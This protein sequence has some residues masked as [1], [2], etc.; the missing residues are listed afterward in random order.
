MYSHM[1][2]S[3]E[4]FYTLSQKFGDDI[5]LVQGAGG[6]SSIKSL[7]KKSFLVKGSGTWLA[8]ANKKEIFLNLRREKLSHD[9]E[10]DSLQPLHEYS[11][12]DQL[13]PSIETLLHLVLPYKYVFHLHCL[14]SIA[15]CSIRNAETTLNAL[16]SRSFHLIDYFPP[17]QPLAEALLE[18]IEAKGP[19]QIFFLKNHGLV[20]VS[21]NLSEIQE[22]ADEIKLLLPP[23]NI[24]IPQTNEVEKVEGFFLPDDYSIQALAFNKNA[25]KIYKNGILYPDHVVFLGDVIPIFKTMPDHGLDSLEYFIHC[26]HGVYLK[27]GLS[28]VKCEMIKA[29]CHLA[30]FLRSEKYNYLSGN[31]LDSLRN[32]PDEIVRQ[33][34]NS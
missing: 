16:I 28:H 11:L 24:Q 22:M 15:L 21:N 19:A 8:D 1:N 18:S 3:L 10:A 20:L 13:K 2:S 31:E 27:E 26:D 12:H 32:R 25:L 5:E 4:D 34:L 7:D 17:G 6:N 29:L 14:R 9:F 30:K 23:K 33:S